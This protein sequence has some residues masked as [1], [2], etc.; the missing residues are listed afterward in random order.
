MDKKVFECETY[1]IWEKVEELQYLNGDFV[2]SHPKAKVLEAIIDKEKD[3][4]QIR[5]HW[6]QDKLKN[7]RKDLILKTYELEML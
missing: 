1:V 2:L 6:V 7:L 4:I 5:Y 3:R